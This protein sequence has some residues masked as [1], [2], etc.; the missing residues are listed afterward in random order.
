MYWPLGAPRIFA[1]KVPG[2]PV[3]T[4]DSDD[5]EAQPR[6]GNSAS[7]KQQE[8]DGA[9]PD[10]LLLHDGT[11]EDGHDGKLDPSSASG[12]LRPKLDKKSGSSL[13]VTFTEDEKAQV[14]SRNLIA[15]KMSRNGALFATITISEL[16]IW[17]T[18]VAMTMNFCPWIG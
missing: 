8:K 4:Y 14:G 18:K 5:S 9:D 16:T 6:I 11:H 1:A 10:D 3:V 15:L 12:G 13:D 17:Q 7:T 2:G